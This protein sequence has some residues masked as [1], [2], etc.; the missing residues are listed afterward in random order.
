MIYFG[1][2]L[3]IWNTIVLHEAVGPPAYIK[4]SC[5]SV[6]QSKEKKKWEP[7]PPPPRV[8][9]KQRRAGQVRHATNGSMH[10]YT[11][12]CVMYERDI[13]VT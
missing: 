9:K 3:I 10:M 8:G 1:D 11:F 7:P 2:I 12:R 4:P 6:L 5:F 13:S